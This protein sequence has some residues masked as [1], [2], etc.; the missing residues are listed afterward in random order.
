MPI[1]L[2]INQDGTVASAQVVDSYGYYNSNQLWQAVA[3]SAL[4]AVESP[5]CS[6]L[7]LP[8]DKFDQWKLTTLNFSPQDLQ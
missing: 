3:D 6:P 1:R 4:R 8:A 7:K 5:S 2:V